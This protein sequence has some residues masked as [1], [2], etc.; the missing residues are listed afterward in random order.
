MLLQRERLERAGASSRAQ[1]QG[2]HCGSHR[3]SDP[4]DPGRE[5]RTSRQVVR[6]GTGR[7]ARLYWALSL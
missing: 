1:R 3:Q 7:G 2:V 4:G 6:D 5:V